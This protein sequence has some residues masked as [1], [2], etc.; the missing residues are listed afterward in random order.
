MIKNNISSFKE[1]GLPANSH[2][3]LDGK[4]QACARS[5]NEIIDKLSHREH[6][7][8][9]L[10]NLLANVI[11]SF[12]SILI[13]V[14]NEKRVQLWNREAS[15]F[16]KKNRQETTKQFLYE[17][18]SPF[19]IETDKL[20]SAINE[21]QIQTIKN[22]A[23]EKDNQAHVFDVAIFPL[24]FGSAKGAIIQID[25]VTAKTLIEELVS[26][27]GLA[28]GMTHEINNPLSGIMLNANVILNRL[29]DTQMPANKRV[30]EEIGISM[31]AI[32]IFIEKRGIIGMLKTITET[33]HRMAEIVDNMLNFAR[34]SKGKHSFYVLEEICE[35]ALALAATYFNLKKQY[36]F[37]MIDIK[38]DYQD[39][40]PP[41]PCER[42]KT[43]Q[44]LLNILR[45]GAQAMQ[46][47]GT[48]NPQF[49]IGT[50]FEKNRKTVCIKIMDNGPGMDDETR[51]RVFEPFFTTKPGGI[52]TGLGLSVSYFIITKTHGGEMSVTSSP[53]KG[54]T[55]NIRLPLEGKHGIETDK[56][57]G[58]PKFSSHGQTSGHA[59]NFK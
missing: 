23:Y 20:Q 30:A 42:T 7:L 35:K 55:F 32:N 43:Q 45:N 50:Q 37:K 57:I 49:V 14:D 33:G 2:M 48:Q 26:L 36:D 17:C 4:N 59:Q 44:V 21:K 46:E 56:R 12:S 40:L 25:D 19:K 1:E 22:Y 58:E 15:I 24:F 3:Y 13:A 11:D 52:G 27:G 9:H 34:K 51:K 53:G 18:I 28:A 10:H 31:S 54:A 38:K 47:A 39:N 5:F 29:T 16:F 8:H 6:E 41:V